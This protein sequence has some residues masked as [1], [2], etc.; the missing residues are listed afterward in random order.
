MESAHVWFIPEEAGRR[1]LP[2]LEGG[3]DDGPAAGD[4]Q[5]VLVLGG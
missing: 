1:R 4:H 5:G 2:L 3:D